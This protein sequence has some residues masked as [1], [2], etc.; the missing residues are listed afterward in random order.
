MLREDKEKLIAEKTMA[1]FKELFHKTNEYLR[2]TEKPTIDDDDF[3]TGNN[4]TE[5]IDELMKLA[6]FPDDKF[7]NELDEILGN[8]EII[9]KKHFPEMYE[10]KN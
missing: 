2:K 6:E 10:E 3:N 5:T 9:H 7:E 4:I 1:K 8:I